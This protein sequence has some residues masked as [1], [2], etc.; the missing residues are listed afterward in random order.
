MAEADSLDHRSSKKARA[1]ADPNQPTIEQ[2]LSKVYKSDTDLDVALCFYGLGI[3]LHI[4]QKPLFKRMT[5]ALQKAGP[6]YKLP[7]YD[8]LR[9]PLLQTAKKHVS[10]QLKDVKA[11]IP[12]TGCGI[13]SD[14]WS[15]VQ[16]RPLLNILQLTPAGSIFLRAIDTTG[17]TKTGEYIA[18]QLCKAIEEV[19]SENVVIVITDSASN[20]KCAGDIIMER[21]PHITW[22][23]CTAHQLDLVLEEI[24][25]T[26]WAKEVIDAGKQVVTFINN[27]H[28]SLGFFRE[29]EKLELLKPGETRFATSFIMLARLLRVKAALQETVADRRWDEWAEK[30]TYRDDAATCKATIMSASFWSPVMDLVQI[31]TPIVKLLRLTDGNVPCM[32]K[33]YLECFEALQA[34][35]DLNLPAA[36]KDPIAAM[37][38]T[39]WNKLHSIMHAAGYVLDPEF[40]DHEQEKNEEVMLGFTAV[41]EKLLPKVE[42]QAEALE[43]LNKFKSKRGLFGMK[44]VQEA[45]KRM[46]AHSWWQRYGSSC[47]ELQR[48][49][50]RVLSQVSSASSCERNWSNYDFIHNRKRNRLQP[51]RADDLVYVFSNLRLL[52]EV[53]D[54]DYEDKYVKWLEGDEEEEQQLVED[55]E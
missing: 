13:T 48:V 43:Q 11:C 24:G 40:W 46:P 29:R 18:E 21:Y 19:G 53:T 4:I 49:A 38:E 31:S 3:P 15:S 22:V 45:A 44:A 34:I 10:T 41:V 28:A 1:V 2:A 52:N 37:F 6:K 20:C 54:L 8:A 12:V 39:R 14:G 47:P 23:P 7:S 9:G 17:E 42:D 33:V 55:A 36:K 16:R 35:Q 5:S 32:G 50:V 51:L 25:K 27:H 30:Q 26:A